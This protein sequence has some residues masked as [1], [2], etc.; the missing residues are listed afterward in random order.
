MDWGKSKNILIVAFLIT[1]LILG[2]FLLRDRLAKTPTLSDDFIREVEKML[3]EKNIKLSTDIPKN[4]NGL[5]P[6]TVKYEDCDIEHIRQVLYKGEVQLESSGNE[7]IISDKNSKTTIKSN[8]FLLYENVS[9][10]KKFEYIEKEEAKKLADDFINELGYYRDDMELTF[11]E[12][13]GEKYYITYS[14]KYEDV[15]VEK[16][17]MDIV[18]SS[19]GVESFER[20]WLEIKAKGDM[21]IYTSTAPKAILSLLSMDEA[22]G[23]DIIEI[24]LV[25]YF[26]PQQHSYIETLENAKEGKTVPAWRILFKNGDRI[27]IDNY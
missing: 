1:N 23:K 26:D 4:E 18:V 5:I 9:N 13:N 24:S 17:Y 12:K 11:F 8:K 25:H 6:L 19:R 27:I 20:I 22:Y 2:G 16:A 7:D 21:E 15:L 14:K 3:N 10:E